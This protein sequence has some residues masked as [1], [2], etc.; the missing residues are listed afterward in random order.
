MP[1][2]LDC[3]LRDG[4]FINDWK[5]GREKIINI[6]ERAVSAGTDIIELCFIDERREFD[7]HR[8]I[9]PDFKSVNEIFKGLDSGKSMLVGMID[10]GTCSIE[11]AIPCSE[12]VMDGI[13]VIFKKKNRFE[14][15]DFCGQLKKLGYKVFVQPVSVTGYS[16]EEFI[17]LIERV[18]ELSPAA[19][20]VVD[21]Y[22]LLHMQGV[23]HYY[24]LLEK[25]LKTDISIGYHA[26][27]NFQMAYSNCIALLERNAQASEARHHTLVVDGSSFGMGKGAGNAPIELLAMY[28]NENFDKHYDI[29]QMLETIDVSIMDIYLKTPWGYSLKYFLAASNDC[30][31]TYVQHLMQKRTLSVKSVNEILNRI[32]PK[33]KLAYNAEHIENLYQDYQ[34]GNGISDNEQIEQLKKE[35]S[36]SEVLVLGPAPSMQLEQDKI[37]AFIAKNKPIVVSINYRPEEF[38][39]DYIFIS[40]SKRYVALEGRI[41]ENSE[42]IAPGSAKDG[43]KSTDNSLKNTKTAVHIKTIATSNI[44]PARGSFDYQVDYASLIDPEFEFSDSSLIMLLKL[45]IRLGL[46]KAYLAGFDGYSMKE[47]ENYFNVAMEYAFVKDKAQLLNEY[48]SASLK[49]IH[50]HLELEFITDTRYQFH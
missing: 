13:R 2:L 4:G 40:N 39:T 5:F 34:R 29:S 44:T 12:S 43:Q 7:P 30:H 32:A 49:K 22:G 27:N 28:L 14:A 36:S 47:G 11:K 46:K 37:Q 50:E 20:S 41:F 6:F 25:H 26:H 19:M 8:S 38:Y 24:E 33:E 48:M 10:Y 15:I 18:N 42:N 23:L 45:F 31:P 1:L 3:T 16:D 21:T 9:I 35:L 17:E